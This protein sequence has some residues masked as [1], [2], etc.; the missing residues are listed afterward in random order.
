MD[1]RHERDAL[2]LHVG[3]A[4]NI[5]NRVTHLGGKPSQGF[6][7]I[8]ENLDRDL[9][10][11]TGKNVVDAVGNRLA[12]ADADAGQGSQLGP[13][14]REYLGLRAVGGVQLEFDLRGVDLHDVLVSLGTAGAPRDGA[15]FGNLREE[16]LG[17]AADA[18]ALF[19]RSSGG[20][21]DKRGDAAF[22]E[23]R[24]ELAPESR[25]GDESG[26]EET[27]RREVDAPR[28]LE[29]VVEQFGLESFDF[30]HD[31]SVPAVFHP[32]HARKQ[33]RA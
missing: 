27:R 22:V 6:Q 19:E 1:L 11:H 33:Q 25:Q 15:G 10:L 18:V 12:H 23:F 24:Q 30:A 21:D 9:R 3:H 4:R 17:H 20:G 28:R 7:V 5:G 32:L 8:A 13:D 2:D 16:F 26:D 29:T 31:P 14:V